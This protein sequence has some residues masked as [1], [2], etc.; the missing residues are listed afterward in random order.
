MIDYRRR[1]ANL[2]GVGRL[3]VLDDTGP[4][5]LV[6]TDEGAFVPGEPV[7]KLSDRVPRIFEFG[8]TSYPPMKSEVILCRLGGN[9]SLQIVIGTNHQPSR[10]RDLKE[11]DAAIYDVRGARIWLSEDG[12]IIDGAGLPMTIQNA[13]TI[14]VKAE[15]KVRIESPLV[16]VTGDVV[17]RAD[18]SRVS[19]NNLRDAYE[20]HAHGGVQTGG[21]ATGGTDHPA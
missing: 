16:E 10:P 13:P 2:L 12:I 11:G 19:L 3:T 14:T 4:T 8:F 9:R 6:Q 20:A 15:T 17:S 5:Q 7:K 18:G 21:S 1:I